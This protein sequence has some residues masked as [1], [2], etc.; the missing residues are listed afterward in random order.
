MTKTFFLALVFACCGWNSLY[1]QEDPF[2]SIVKAF[3]ESDAG[4]L[5]EWFNPTVE[6]LLPEH[7]NTYS[8]SQAE[9]IIKEFF[10]KCPAE[11]FNILEKGATDPESKFAIG[12]YSTK[13]KNYKVYTYLRKENEQFLIHKIRFDEKK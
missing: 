12:E 3:E 6:L 13:E 1:S 8:A 10:K 2:N 11:K 7:Q 5:A 4:A 9:M